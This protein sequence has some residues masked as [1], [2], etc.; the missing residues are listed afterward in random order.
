MVLLVLK[1]IDTVS[2]RVSAVAS[3]QPPPLPQLR[4]ARSLLL[5]ADT[6]KAALMVL[7]A[8]ATAPLLASA[9]F[10]RHRIHHGPGLGGVCPVAG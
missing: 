5:T 1:L 4:P 3:F 2:G 10:V 7:E 6:G 8:D 9:T